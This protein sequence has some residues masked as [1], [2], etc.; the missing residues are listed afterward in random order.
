MAVAW[1]CA[2]ACGRTGLGDA[3]VEG[4]TARGEDAAAVATAPDVDATERVAGNSSD[5]T[6]RP[7]ADAF[8]GSSLGWAARPDPSTASSYLVNSAHTGAIDDATLM[9]PI[10]RAWSRAFD[11][12]TSYP[13]IAGGLVYVIVNGVWG[14]S[15]SSLVALNATTGTN[16]WGPVDAGGAFALALD[17]G[18]LF[19]LDSDTHLRAFDAATGQSIWTATLIEPPYGG[20]ASAPPTA[21]RGIVYASV[22]N[23]VMAVDERDG[24]VLWKQT[25]W[26]SD[27]S[28]PT[29]SDFAAFASYFCAQDYAFDRVSGQ[30]LWHHAGSC[31]AGQ[32]GTPMLVGNTLF[33][34]D[35]CCSS[36]S[37]I[38]VDAV[39]GSLVGTFSA[40]L[41]PAFHGGRAYFVNTAS[42]VSG[43]VTGALSA[44]DMATGSNLWTFAGDGFIAT[45]PLV[46][47]GCV[48]V[49]SSE[50]ALFGVA[51]TTGAQTFQDTTGA[52]LESESVLSI[53]PTDVALAAGDGVLVVPAGSTL[54]GYAHVDAGPGVATIDA[55]PSAS[56]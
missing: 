30:V 11:A 20:S 38:T 39:S 53:Q 47:G 7:G 23:T 4:A 31:I 18:R 42:R 15:S 14:A 17:G 13:L 21:Y 46:V 44:I 43:V 56:P 32:G 25:V 37:G 52:A 50:G 19:T 40:T 3:L 2:S 28:A 45:S 1:S 29:V 22:S 55:S 34:R 51:E 49:G 41:P 5:A 36:S 16:V 12:P 10:G 27:I 35:D 8:T 24:S 6:A 54:L 9:R 48:Y 33:T 26:G